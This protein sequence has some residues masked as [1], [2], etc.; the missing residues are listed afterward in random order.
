MLKYIFLLGQKNINFATNT[1]FFKTYIFSRELSNVFGAG[2]KV[3]F[4]SKKDSSGDH[5]RRA[6]IPHIRAM[7]CTSIFK[8]AIGRDYQ[9]K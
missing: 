7:V 4:N 2:S 8:L 9:E 1:C 6:Q 5:F 3:H